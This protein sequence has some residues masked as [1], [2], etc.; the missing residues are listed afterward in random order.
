VC[1]LRRTIG[2][3]NGNKSGK[4]QQVSIENERACEG[5][6][7]LTHIVC[8][9]IMTTQCKAYN[10]FQLRTYTDPRCVFVFLLSPCTLVRLPRGCV[11]LCPSRVR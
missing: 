6:K 1:K 4:Q 5:E 7:N 11:G 9:F 3:E 2:K 8:A 10:A